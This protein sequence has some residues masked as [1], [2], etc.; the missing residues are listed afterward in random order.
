MKAT[1]LPSGS[2]TVLVYVGKDENGKPVRKRFTDPDKR[3]V[4]Q[5]AATY[6]D[7]HR[8]TKS[9]AT[10]G[11]IAETVAHGKTLSV[12]TQRGYQSIL[13]AIQTKYPRFYAAPLMSIDSDEIQDLIDDL[14]EDHSPKTVRNWNGFIGSVFKSKKLRAPLVDLPPKEAVD[15]H[16]PTD[17]E[18][19]AAL[20]AAL[21][22]GD[23][24]L[25]VCIALGAFG[26]LR[27]GEVAALTYHYEE[28]ID[29]DAGTIH[30]SHSLART[31]EG[32]WILKV[33]K[34]RTS[35]RVIPMPKEVMER[36]REQGYVTHWNPEQIYGKFSSLLRR[37]G[38]PHFR[39]H[40]LRH[41]GASYLHAKGYPDA[42]I[43]ART[44]HASNEVLRK[45]YTH[46]LTEE[47][48]EIS[49]EMISDFEKILA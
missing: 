31:S 22:E 10:F 40:D 45:V 9:S 47:Q 5:K 8:S 18:V 12:T 25:W 41:Y 3:T 34:T 15:Y 21:A 7:D 26:P 33:P 23:V 19:R 44:G 35:D 17:S 16:I 24:E 43:Q 29:F 46:V 28:D 2:W 14:A 1:K 32:E 48:K 30:V 37:N 13:R 6:V 20:N 27:A 11:A 42:Y 36:I 39:F 49:A 38:I 4:M